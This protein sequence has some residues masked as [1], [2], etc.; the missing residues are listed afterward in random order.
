VK[1]YFK[2]MPFWKRDERCIA[3][4]SRGEV[5]TDRSVGVG[6]GQSKVNSECGVQRVLE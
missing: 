6:L 2:A 5:P 4:Q 1:N 3:Q